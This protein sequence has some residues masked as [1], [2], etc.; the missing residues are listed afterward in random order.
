M[1]LEKWTKCIKNLLKMKSKEGILRNILV[2]NEKFEI[3]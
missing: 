1:L 2:S 3:K